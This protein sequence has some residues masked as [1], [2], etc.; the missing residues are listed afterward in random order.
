MDT[1]NRNRALIGAAAALLAG[2]SVAAQ[3]ADSLPPGVTPAMVAQGKKLFGGEGLCIA[4]HGPDARGAIGPNLTDATWLHGKGSFE[5]IVT[6]IVEGVPAPISK[7]GIV[8]PPKGG[9]KL[10]DEQ[11]K[12]VAAYVWSLG[13]AA[14]AAAVAPF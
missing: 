2:A 8:M 4:C 1:R 6:R 10:K 14:R 12:A 3:Q 9:S 7:S 13:R 11:V 5:E